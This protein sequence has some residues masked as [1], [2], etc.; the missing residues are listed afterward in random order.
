MKKEMLIRSLP[1]GA[2]KFE[3]SRPSLLSALKSA[4]L[5]SAPVLFLA[6]LYGRV[7]DCEVTPRQALHLTH[8]QLAFYLMLFPLEVSVPVRLLFAVWFMLTAVQCRRA[9]VK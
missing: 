6:R 5:R 8:A 9:G 2:E 1:A 3:I 7:L 4:L